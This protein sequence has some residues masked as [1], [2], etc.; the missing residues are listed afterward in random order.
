M[1]A[2]RKSTRPKYRPDVSGPE[3]ALY[4]KNRAYLLKTGE[5][6][7]L[8]GGYIDK[9]LKFPDPMS[10]SVDHIIPVA[11]GG[12]STLDN[13]QLTHLACNKAK[14]KKIIIQK[15]EI[16]TVRA[17]LPQSVDWSSYRDEL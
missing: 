13:L 17:T 6:C 12:K 1:T 14:G 10:P 7:S 15:K 16:S 3:E 8:C 9:S 11:K 4:K 2:R 5:R